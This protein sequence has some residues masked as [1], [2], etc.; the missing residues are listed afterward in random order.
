MSLTRKDFIV[1]TFRTGGPG[2]QKQNKTDSGVRITHKESGASSESRVHRSQHE[3]KKEALQ[4]LSES[5]EF[6]RWVF[7]KLHDRDNNIVTDNENIAVVN[8]WLSEGGE[9]DESQVKTEFFMDGRWVE[10]KEEED[11]A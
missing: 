9:F 5:F 6:K 3:N 10:I 11:D 8:K 4:K 2:G 1:Q 7:N